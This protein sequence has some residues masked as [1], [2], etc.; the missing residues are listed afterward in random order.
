MSIKDYLKNHKEMLN[1]MNSDEYTIGSK[2]KDEI[3]Y[4]YPDLKTQLKYA[5]ILAKTYKN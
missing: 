3:I 2:V 1:E 5:K 4:I